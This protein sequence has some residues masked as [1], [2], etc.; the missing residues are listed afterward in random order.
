[1][2][3]FPEY[4]PEDSVEKPAPLNKLKSHISSCTPE[5]KPTVALPKATE[6]TQAMHQRDCCGS[7]ERH[8][9]NSVSYAAAAQPLTEEEVEPESQ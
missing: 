9:V 6:D 3:S 5:L 2:Q 7:Q 1:M 8:D 4:K